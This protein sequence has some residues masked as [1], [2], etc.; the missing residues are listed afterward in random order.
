M[1][2]RYL[3]TRVPGTPYSISL[4]KGLTSSFGAFASVVPT[5]VQHAQETKIILAAKA[6]G[7]M[8]PFPFHRMA[9]E[10]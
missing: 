6:D 10:P 3:G 8:P 7:L 5:F 9:P 1:A 4:K 2:R